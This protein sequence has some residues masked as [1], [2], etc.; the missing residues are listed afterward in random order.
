MALKTGWAG[1][2]N[3]LAVR[4]DSMGDVL[5]SSPALAAMRLSSPD[6][7]LTLLTSI[8]GARTARHVDVVD[9]TLVYAAPWVAPAAEPSS[10]RAD[11]AFINTLAQRGFDAAVIFTV[12]TQ[13]ALPAALACRLAGIPLRL[14]HS[15]ENP[16]A[17]LTDWVRDP[18]TEIASARH[19]VQRQLDLVREVGF[20]TQ[21]QHLRMRYDHADALRMQAALAE[22]GGDVRRPYIVVHAGARAASRRY[23][24]PLYGVVARALQARTGMQLVFTGSD[25]EADLVTQA[26]AQMS[27]AP[28]DLAGKL[29]L[30]ELAALLDGAQVLL[31][32]NTGPAHMAAALGT[33]VVVL[34]ALTNPQ[35][36]PWQVP[37]RVLSHDVPCRNCLKSRC[38]EIHH[39]CLLRI[40][41]ETVVEATLDLLA[42][43]A[44]VPHHGAAHAAARWQHHG[45]ARPAARAAVG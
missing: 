21:D 29:G 13:S 30:G 31:C 5:M 43:S 15:R 35:H 39:D 19:E 18:D 1:A 25:G 12:C 16:Y 17:L 24:A 7:R 44:S 8:E 45:A 33:P 26:A 2:R 6:V 28:V 27:Q 41:P 9:D 32:N 34:Y 3:I 38:P 14:A 11:L 36:T 40:A 22:A 23:P 10:H 37:A 42:R 4:L 20:E